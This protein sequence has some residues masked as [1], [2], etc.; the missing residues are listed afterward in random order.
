MKVEMVMTPE[1]CRRQTSKNSKDPSAVIAHLPTPLFSLS[2]F[3]FQKG[4]CV[5]FHLSLHHVPILLPR[6]HFLWKTLE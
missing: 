4:V 1:G 3:L 6:F 2:M 5:L